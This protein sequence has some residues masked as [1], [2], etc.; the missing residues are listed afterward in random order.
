MAGDSDGFCDQ[1][2]AMQSHPQSP[3]GLME[4]PSGSPVTHCD[5]FAKSSFLVETLEMR[6]CEKLR[7][8]ELPTQGHS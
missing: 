3:A 1:F 5:M 7:E 6:D 8:E 2:T 4:G